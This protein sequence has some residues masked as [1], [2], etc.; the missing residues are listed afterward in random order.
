MQAQGA[1]LRTRRKVCIGAFPRPAEVINRKLPPMKLLIVDDD[2]KQHERYKIAIDE[3]NKAQKAS[4]Q[5]DLRDNVEGGMQSLDMD[6][7]GAV[8][9]LRLSQST[10]SAEGNRVIR[11][12]KRRKRFPVVVLTG[13]PGD[14]DADLK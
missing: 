3:F 5:F 13:F 9:D 11:E 7:D 4:V 14:L 2:P 6:Y 1:L 10:E 8:I 12:I